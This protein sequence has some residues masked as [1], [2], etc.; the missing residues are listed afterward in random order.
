MLRLDVPDR[1]DE[2]EVIV[3]HQPLDLNT[4]IERIIPVIRN[5]PARRQIGILVAGRRQ[6]P[7]RIERIGIGRG[8]NR[9]SRP[10]V[11]P[12]RTARCG[13]RHAER[14]EI[15]PHREPFG[16]GVGIAD[17]I[18]AATPDRH[19]VG[20]EFERHG[21]RTRRRPLDGN[22]QLARTFGESGVD[23]FRHR[24]SV[25]RRTGDRAGNFDRL[26]SRSANV[27]QTE[28]G[29][30]LDIPEEIALDARLAVGELARAL[31]DRNRIGR[32]V[33]DQMDGRRPLG[34]RIILDVQ[35]EEPVVLPVARTAFGRDRDPPH[36]AAVGDPL[37]V[38]KDVLRNRLLRTVAGDRIVFPHEHPSVL[39][40]GTGEQQQGEERNEA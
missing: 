9:I 38:A 29:R 10:A 39:L 30:A 4:R 36:V 24:E 6:Q 16:H 21:T 1:N 40:A 32:A 7:V 26:A 33:V 2:E 14:I 28:R 25:G 27:R 23:L 34:P 20:E 35:C 11:I 3:L 37:A 8:M 22:R 13:A 5:H 12:L 17:D 18:G 15:P 31:R 19:A